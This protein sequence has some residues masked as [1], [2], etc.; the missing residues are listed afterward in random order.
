MYSIISTLDPDANAR[1]SH[2]R[3]WLIKKYDILE[4]TVI[5]EPHL[6]WLG[7]GGLNP[8]QVGDILMRYSQ[9]ITPI[10]LAA[11]GFGIFTGEEP[12]L[13]LPVIKTA[14]LVRVHNGLWTS[15]ESQLTDEVVYFRPDEWLP[16]ISLFYFTKETLGPL[17]SILSD[18]AT[19][20]F[21]LHFTINHFKLAF[22]H[23]GTYGHQSQYFFN[24]PSS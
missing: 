24:Q 5:L 17:G 11:T 8:A 4:K 15:L 22:F 21:Q 3:Y 18:L 13:Y 2:L 1:V 16:H 12:V 7:A 19:L 10:H 9:S 14:E 23:D 20:D 6:S